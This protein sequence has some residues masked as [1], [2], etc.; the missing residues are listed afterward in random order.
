LKPHKYLKKQET[1][2][3]INKESGF[4]KKSDLNIFRNSSH[5]NN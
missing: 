4:K 2:K 3:T 1:L 5:F